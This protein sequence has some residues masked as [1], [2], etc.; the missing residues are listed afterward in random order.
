MPLPF[1]QSHDLGTL[2]QSPDEEKLWLGRKTTSIVQSCHATCVVWPK[3][4]APFACGNFLFDL[5][6]PELPIL[7]ILAAEFSLASRQALSFTREAELV[8]RVDHQAASHWSALGSR[9]PELPSCSKAP[10]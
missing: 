1:A 7:Q 8:A 10:V 6:M 9:R 2:R 5:N 4:I 3:V